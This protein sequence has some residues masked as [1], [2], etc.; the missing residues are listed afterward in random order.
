MASAGHGSPYCK[1]RIY[2]SSCAKWYDRSIFP[3]DE[4]RPKCPDVSCRNFLR[5]KPRNRQSKLRYYQHLLYGGNN[6][7][8]SFEAVVAYVA[9]EEEQNK[10]EHDLVSLP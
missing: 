10:E 8:D 4:I 5:Q 2:C 1:N 6:K 3:A 9:L 7:E